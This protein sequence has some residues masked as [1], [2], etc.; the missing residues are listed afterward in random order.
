[1][2]VAL[3]CQMIYEREIDEHGKFR[4]DLQYAIWRKYRCG[5]TF[6]ESFCQERGISALADV[7]LEVLEDFRPTRRIGQIAWKVEL[8]TLRTFF[9][10]C[11]SHKWITANLAK[12]IKSPRN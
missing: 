3:L 4:G 12:E 8:Q 6:L 2:H 7:T 11:I 1:M 5:L 10:Y 9:A